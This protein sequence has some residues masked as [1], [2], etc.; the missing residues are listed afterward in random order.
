MPLFEITLVLLTIAVVLLQVARRLRVPYPSLLALAGGCVAL[1]PFAPHLTIQPQL[2]LAL[3]VAPAVLDMAFDMPPREL[4]R[5]WVPVVSLA[6][7]LVLLT[8]AAVAWAGVALAGL[9]AAA[10]IA[11]GAIVAPPDA[12]AA[13]AVLR[14][15]SLPRRTVAVLQ[16][17]S[18][19]N[20][21]VALLVFGLA[22]TAA[23]S[24]GD[25]WPALA[26]RLLIAVPGGAAL[27]VLSAQLGMRIFQKV[28]GTLS[29]IIVQFLFTYGT[30]LA[31]ERLQLSPIVAIVTLAAVI[32]RYMPSRT[33]ARDR[34]NSLAVWATVVFVLNVL[35]FL[36]MGL[37]ARVILSQLQSEALTHALAF[38]GIV[39]GIVIGVR[40]AYVML[41]GVVLRFFS[42]FFEKRVLH[43]KVPDA[44]IGVLVSWCGMRGLVTLATALALPQ[45]FPG[46]DVIVLSAFMVVLGTLI[47]Q[48]FTIRPLI[49]LLRIA[50]D[51]SLDEEVARTRNAML[52]AALR[53]LAQNSSEGA[54]ALRAEYAAA[55]AGSVDR[56]EPI[57]VFDRIRI[58]AIAAERR[59]LSEMRRSGRIQD[60]TY[61]LL[62]GE[63]DRAELHAATTGTTS[64]DG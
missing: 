28:A 60:D 39:L 35:A 50:P 47:L 57:T 11:L 54:A 23:V 51:S 52:D 18:L 32:A 30:W 8:T 61:H 56:S 31:A 15:F 59:I 48:G 13:A 33:S 24:P 64:L 20:D 55:R 44:K 16:G 53:E 27:G 5:I 21:A 49:T 14:E 45:Q 34:I 1:L 38:A 40:F 46:R 6:V 4:L 43:A 37:Q 36:L 58:K 12:A 29:L 42:G 10:A 26:P 25:A 17:E 41:Y 62:E 9:P 7:I 2:A 3:F 19:L 22:V 63:L